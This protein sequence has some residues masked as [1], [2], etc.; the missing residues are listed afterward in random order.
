[1]GC[2]PCCIKGM[3]GQVSKMI[4]RSRDTD[5]GNDISGSCKKMK[6]SE[7][8]EYLDTFP[9][10]AEVSVIIANPKERKQLKPARGRPVGL[11]WFSPDCKHF[12][13]AKGGKPKDKFIRG[14][15]VVHF[16]K[17]E[18]RNE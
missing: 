7:L 4:E 2:I 11:A 15:T 17:G 10:D 3:T 9:A 8:K 1:M 13:K 16:R 14:L 6:N 12:S 18:S 5:Q